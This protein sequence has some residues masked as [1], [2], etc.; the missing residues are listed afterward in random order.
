MGGIEKIVLVVVD[1][2]SLSRVAVGCFGGCADAR[3]VYVCSFS[4]SPS[5]P[6]GVLVWVSPKSDWFE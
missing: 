4:Y 3:K 1:I 5:N 6:S 2:C